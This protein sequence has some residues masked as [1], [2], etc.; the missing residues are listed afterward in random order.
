ML[1]YAIART[2][3]F[4]LVIATIAV[5]VVS[6]AVET[7]TADPHNG[8][9]WIG[10]PSQLVLAGGP[11]VLLAVGLRSGARSVARRT[12]I[13]AAVFAVVVGFVLVMQLLDPNE[14]ARDRAVQAFVLVLFLAVFAV[15]ASAFDGRSPG[16][17]AGGHV[18]RR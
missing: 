10:G 6:S 13:L 4:W 16:S 7:F 14:T 15:E 5:V 18:R 8:E 17:R 1:R 3:V 12:A 2:A 9:G 11:L